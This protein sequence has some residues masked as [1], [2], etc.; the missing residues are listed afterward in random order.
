M[1]SK[2]AIPAYQLFSMKSLNAALRQTAAGR[3]RPLSV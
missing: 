1:V 2:G 3:V